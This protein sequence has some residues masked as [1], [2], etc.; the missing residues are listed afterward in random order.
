MGMLITIFY[1]TKHLPTSEF[2][3][4]WGPMPLRPFSHLLQ[5]EGPGVSYNKVAWN[6]GESLL[7]H[8]LVLWVKE[9]RAW[10]GSFL[11]F[12]HFTTHTMMNE[13]PADA[14]LMHTCIYR[15]GP[16]ET[17]KQGQNLLS[18]TFLPSLFHLSN[19]LEDCGPVKQH[20][21]IGNQ[22]PLD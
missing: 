2:G 18:T 7:W 1:S 3:F 8:C 17:V 9:V 14:S 16:R 13:A 6:E 22:I 20:K 10:N 15:F 21:R 4:T 11:S 12:D 19:P 5:S